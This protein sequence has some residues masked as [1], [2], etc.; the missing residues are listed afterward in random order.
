[1]ILN[2]KRIATVPLSRFLSS[3]MRGVLLLV[4]SL[5]APH[6]L[7]AQPAAPQPR[8]APTASEAGCLI[9]SDFGSSVHKNFETFVLQGN[10][11]VHYWRDNSNVNYA[12]V[13]GQIISSQAT[14]PGCGVQ[15]DFHSGGHGNFEVVVPEGNNLVHY[16]RDNSDV[17]SPWRRGQIISNHVTG[18]ASIIQSDFQSGGHGNFEVIVREGANLIHYW[19]DNSDVNSPWRRGQT[20]STQISSAASI[21]QSNFHN[22]DHSNFEVVAREGNN[23]V[24]FWHDNSDVNS[25]WRR[26]QNISTA[27]GGAAQ[28]IQSDFH[29]GDHGNFEVVTVESGSLVH[30]WHDNSDVNTPWQRGQTIAPSVS[31]A[32]GFI[33]SNF[34]S[35]NHG[36]FEVVA[37]TDGKVIHHWHDNGDVNTPWRLGQVVTPSARSQK[38]CQ[39][40]GDFDFQ[41]RHETKNRTN[42]RFSVS[43]TDLGYPFE[44]DGRLYLLFGDTHGGADHGPD[45]LAFTRDSDPEICPSLTFVADGQVF[46]PIQAPG[47]SLDWFEVPTTGFSV[48]GAMYVFV[49]TDHKDNFNGTFSDPVGHAAPPQGFRGGIWQSG[50]GLA[51]DRHGN[52][53]FQTGN[54]TDV[55]E[56]V[57]RSGHLL[58]QFQRKRLGAATENKRGRNLVRPVACRV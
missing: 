32:I 26:G 38:I 40:T 49:W 33:Q 36:N 58:V 10:N 13:R 16:W 14:G 43:G 25:P 56:P 9:Q 18:P 1:M 6:R 5:F 28:I 20:I 50:N 30:Y 2:L 11:L 54:K 34:H 57:T 55:L 29:N 35:G 45:S 21:I 15:S 48:N 24:H 39:M 4:L 19:H 46:R 53:Y 37:G 8:P 23:L 42:S 3:F 7:V 52:V 41:N 44:H 17:A 51:A 12:W 27:A 47:V 31:G 22:G